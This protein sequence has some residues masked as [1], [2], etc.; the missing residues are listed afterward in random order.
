MNKLKIHLTILIFLALLSCKSTKPDNSLYSLYNQAYQSLQNDDFS[1]AAEKFEK[2]QDDFPFSTWSIKAKTM[3]A[4]AYYR[5]KDLAKTLAITQD[6]TRTNYGSKYL[7]YMLY[8]QG[9]CHYEKI[10]NQYRSQ[11]SAQEAKNIFEQIILKYPDTIYAG[12]AQE[13]LNFAIEHLAGAKMSIARYQIRT[14]NFVGAINN[15]YSVIND[16]PQSSQ[17]AEAYRR[18]AEIYLKLGIEKQSWQILRFSKQSL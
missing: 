7:P 17:V 6:F 14:Q 12:D 8:M 16:Y 2:V 10:P 5:N 13:K 11:D 18:I 4:Y 15:F 3:M 9:L 1:E